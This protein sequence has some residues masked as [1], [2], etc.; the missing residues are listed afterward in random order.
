[1]YASGI[2]ISSVIVV[3]G[4]VYE[5]RIHPVAIE[6]VFCL[7]EDVRFCVLGSRRLASKRFSTQFNLIVSVYNLNI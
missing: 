7:V 6:T 5:I 3:D 1:M 4:T 2:R